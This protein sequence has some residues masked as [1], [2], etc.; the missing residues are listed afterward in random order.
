MRTKLSGF[1]QL[2]RPELPLAAG[3]CVLLGEIVAL[4]DLPPLRPG[5]LGFVCG[6]FLSGTALVLN[7]YFDLEVDRINA[8]LRPLPSG[9]VSPREV[10]YFAAFTALL[11]LGAALAISLPALLLGL[12]FWTVGFL[13]NWKFKQAGL[14]GNLMVS[15]SVAVTF[16]LGGMAVGEPWNKIVWF[17]SLQAFLIDLGEEIAGDAMDI[18]G[19]LKRGSRSIAIR[20]GKQF[21]LRMASFVFALVVFNSI[22][23]YVLGWLGIGYLILVIIMDLALLYFTSGLLK[24]RTPDEGRSFMRRIY[25]VTL[26]GMLAYIAGKA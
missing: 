8:P 10:I 7:D 4:G 21:A 26:F 9:K 17:F 6:F 14:A 20:K 1:V 15:A 5:L 19:D 13:Y 22:I 23:P 11:G 12:L 25:L 3:I 16:V 18:E 24:S 2:I